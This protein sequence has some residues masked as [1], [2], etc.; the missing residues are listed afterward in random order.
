MAERTRAWPEYRLRRVFESAGGRIESTVESLLHDFG[1]GELTQG[2]RQ[3]VEEALRQA[4]VG[5]EPPLSSAKAGERVSMY[6]S[7]QRVTGGSAPPEAEGIEASAG[8]SK[9]R[10]DRR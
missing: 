10:G 3:N 5:V 9:Q 4:G 8:G 7:E 1:V 2:V 6:L